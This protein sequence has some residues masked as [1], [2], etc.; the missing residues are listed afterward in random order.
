MTSQFTSA[1]DGHGGTL[2]GDPPLPRD[3]Q[4]FHE[5]HDDD[6]GDDHDD[7]H[8]D[9]QPRHNRP[10]I[11]SDDTLTGPGSADLPT[12]EVIS[13]GELRAMAVASDD[14]RTPNVV[15][16]NS[17]GTAASVDD[18]PLPARIAENDVAEEPIS[19]AGG[20]IPT[21]TAPQTFAPSDRNGPPQQRRVLVR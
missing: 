5:H 17:G 10:E 16:V 8:H 21:D 13:G 11:A 18:G 14:G 1:S 7:D 2:I 20:A 12:R 19:A 6:Q 4:Q 15:V 9:D 3:P